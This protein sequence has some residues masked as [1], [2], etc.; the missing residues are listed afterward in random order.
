MSVS[1]KVLQ[2]TPPTRKDVPFA[3]ELGFKSPSPPAWDPSRE[4]PQGGVAQVGGPVPVPV[5]VVSSVPRVARG[6]TY[7]A[8]AVSACRV[9]QKVRAHTYQCIRRQPAPI[10][11]GL[12]SSRPAPSPTLFSSS[13]DSSN[14][15]SPVVSPSHSSPQSCKPFRRPGQSIG[16]RGGSWP[17]R[18]LQIPISH[19]HHIC[20]GGLNPFCMFNELCTYAKSSYHVVDGPI[21]GSLVARHR[22]A[23]MYDCCS[24]RVAL[25]H[26]LQSLGEV[27]I[28]WRVET[29]LGVRGRQSGTRSRG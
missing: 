29:S 3:D 23:L 24:A 11:P 17:S 25:L 13:S 5:L 7:I 2:S 1:V 20:H 26:S 16:A 4:W 21:Q 19:D 18:G 12:G 8:F 14:P 9:P 22:T 27:Q 15:S 10:D 28:D 6:T